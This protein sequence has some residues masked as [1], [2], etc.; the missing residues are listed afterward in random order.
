MDFSDAPLLSTS[1]IIASLIP[2]VFLFLIKWMNFLET[3]H[4]KFILLA[5]LW[6]GISVW[7]SYQVDHPLRLVLGKQF[8]SVHTAPIVEEVFK[9][10]VLLYIVRR[11]G[12]TSFIDGAV[13]GFAA[14]IGF[15]VAEN[16]LYLN[17]FD[18]ETGIVV[19][20]IRAITSTMHGSTTAIVGMA[21]AGFP[22]GGVKHPLIAWI[23]GLL[24]AIG[25]HT[26]Y[27]STAFHNFAFGQTG[28]IV[29]AGI[30]LAALILVALTILWGLGVERRRLRK[31]LGLQRGVTKGEAMLLQRAEDLDEV[32]A[33]IEERYGEVKREQVANALLLAAQ[34]AMK[35]DLLRKTRD[36]ELL[37]EIAPQVTELKR[38]LKQA[39]RDVG[40][41]VMSQVR[42]IVPKTKWSLWAR[43]GQSMAKLGPAKANLWEVLGGRLLGHNSEGESLYRRIQATLAAQESAAALAIA[44]EEEE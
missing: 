2:L 27:N 4:I 9:S 23:I 14:G 29:L 25:I 20:T 41:Y 44:G 42:S 43:L 6:G 34:L 11:G 26:I 5:L 13:Y 18:T 28:L 17:K 24:V 31:S 32:L 33:P 7:L 40:M 37:A 1:I 36:P 21:V 3:H 16:I 35:Q 38:D 30:A 10:L 15:A 22:L 12:A 19:A 8:I 39:R